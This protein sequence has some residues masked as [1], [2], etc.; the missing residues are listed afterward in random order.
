V[1]GAGNK[2]IGG[3]VGK[4]SKAGDGS[5]NILKNKT[6]QEEQKKEEVDESLSGDN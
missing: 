4:L 2:F 3:G 5:P 6:S 1:E